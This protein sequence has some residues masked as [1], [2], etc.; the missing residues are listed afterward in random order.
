LPSEVIVTGSADVLPILES[1][2]GVRKIVNVTPW[3]GGN[4]RTYLILAD[5][6]AADRLAEAVPRWQAWA[7]ERGTTITWYGVAAQ[8]HRSGISIR[9]LTAQAVPSMAALVLVM[10]WILF[11]R[12]GLALLAAW[13]AFVPVAALAS[14]AALARWQLDP[15]TLVIGSITTGLAVDD[16]LQLL[17]T[18]RRRRS[19]IRACIECWR[20]CVGSSLA[21]A[22]CFALFTLSPMGPT[23]QFGLMMTIATLLAMLSNQL[24]VPVIAR[25]QFSR[26]VRQ[27]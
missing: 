1:S 10:V 23:A 15:V 2:P 11:R 13:T 26:I 6:S 16:L 12:A 9:E 25:W 21:A 4:G 22:L 7:A 17:Y 14:I 24:L 19:V 27:S 8:I 5:D 20:P 3:Q 18:T